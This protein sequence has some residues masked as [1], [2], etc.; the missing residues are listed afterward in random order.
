M[1]SLYFQLLVSFILIIIFSLTISTLT[2]Y[3]T[4]SSRLPGLITEITTKSLAHQLS[5]IYTKN[6]DWDNLESEMQRLD[7]LETLNPSDDA[8][9]RIIIRNSDG[10][11]VYNSFLNITRL[12]N[13]ELIEGESF[14]V[15]DFS[16]EETVGMITIYISREYIHRHADIY[17]SGL[18]QS[19]ILKTLITAA[20]A[21]L[22]SLL[23]S[24]RVT[25]PLLELT[26]AAQA[27]TASGQSAQISFESTDELGRLSSAFNRMISALREQQESRKQLVA[28]ISHQINTP[29]NAIRL[30]ARGL[31]DG[32]VSQKEA[33]YHIMKEV[34]KLTNVIYDL[35][36]LSETDSGGYSLNL[37][38]FSAN[39][40]LSEVK[41]HWLNKSEAEGMDI[42]I[43]ECPATPPIMIDVMRISSVIGNLLDNAV[44][45]APFGSRIRLGCREKADSV[46]LYVCDEGAPIPLNERGRIFER[47]YRAEKHRESDKKGSGLGLSIVKQIVEKHGGNVRLECGDGRGNCFIISLPAVSG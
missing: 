42:V 40:L 1:K 34:D 47:F 29:L 11:T 10:K 5:S 33:S 45:Y 27:I 37:Q 7:N 12:G 8:N 39:L 2:E 22:F 32:L 13:S 24:R 4:Y 38:K 17:I 35:D 21:F 6:R 15:I 19:S 18:L 9:L 3:Y 36:W 46:E 28:D 16:T 20:I 23:L 41:G 31:S 14:P 30:E 43:E 25:R 26:D 44:K